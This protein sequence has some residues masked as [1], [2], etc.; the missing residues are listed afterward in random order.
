MWSILSL[1]SSLFPKVEIF[2]C[3]PCKLDSLHCWS[4][5][6]IEALDRTLLCP[7]GTESLFSINFNKVGYLSFLIYSTDRTLHQRYTD[8]NSNIIKVFNWP[9]SDFSAV[10]L[11]FHCW[12]QAHNLEGGGVAT[13]ALPPPLSA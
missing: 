13:V 10:Y 8:R 1:A 4:Q 3:S 6:L 12:C 11:Y 2:I 9:V 5:R 7:L